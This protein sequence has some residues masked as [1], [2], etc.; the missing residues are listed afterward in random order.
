[1]KDEYV[2]CTM[3]E[4]TA[5]VLD[6]PLVLVPFILKLCNV[7]QYVSASAFSFVSYKPGT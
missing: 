2:Q 1:M 5:T 7:W 6:K 4:N 3:S